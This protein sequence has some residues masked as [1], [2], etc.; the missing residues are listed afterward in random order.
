MMRSKYILGIQSRQIRPGTMHQNSC[1]CRHAAMKNDPIMAI[2]KMA[3]GDPIPS[4]P[5]CSAVPTMTAIM[6]RAQNVDS[7]WDSSS[8]HL[9]LSSRQVAVYTTMGIRLYWKEVQFPILKAATKAPTNIRNI[10]PGPK[11]K[12]LLKIYEITRTI[13]KYYSNWI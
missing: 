7:S 2:K 13:Y 1:G 5:N 10:V 12:K 6:I 9:D 4:S 11:N 3:D 8:C